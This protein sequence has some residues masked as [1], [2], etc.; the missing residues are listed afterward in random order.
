M[1]LRSRKIA[2]LRATHTARS[3]RLDAR[4]QRLGITRADAIRLR[5]ELD[6]LDYLLN[7]IQG[8]EERM[9]AWGDDWSKD[10]HP[11]AAHAGCRGRAAG[12]HFY[13]MR[14]SDDHMH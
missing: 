8:V 2:G 12:L 6:E 7:D 3:R 13:Q 10:D 11:H 4:L 9:I 1:G 5:E 14:T